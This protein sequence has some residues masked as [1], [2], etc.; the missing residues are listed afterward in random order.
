MEEANEI[1]TTALETKFL[2]NICNELRR[3][4]LIKR[5]P[6]VGRSGKVHVL[7]YLSE[8]LLFHQHLSKK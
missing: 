7:P 8:R 2:E 4:A 5:R 6:D 3:V 1:I